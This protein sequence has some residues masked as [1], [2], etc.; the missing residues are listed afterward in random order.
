MRVPGVRFKAIRHTEAAWDIGL[1][2]RKGPDLSPLLEAFLGTAL[3]VFGERPK[4]AKR[5]GA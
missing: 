3:E 5:L 2:W 4:G 1:A